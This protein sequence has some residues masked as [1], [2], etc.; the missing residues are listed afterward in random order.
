[1]VVI[2]SKIRPGRAGFV[3]GAGI[4][5]IGIVAGIALMVTGVVS[6]INQLPGFTA[7]IDAGSPQS[8]EIDQA[9]TWALYSGGQDAT[10]SGGTCAIESSSGSTVTT[11][12]PSASV[13]FTRDSRQWYWLA[14]FTVDAPGTY[15]FDCTG[16][17]SVDRFAVG[18]KPDI[19]GFAGRLVGGILGLLALPCG[20]FTI[21]LII[22]IVTAVRRSSARRKLQPVRYPTGYP[23][24]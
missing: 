3:V 7:E 10:S 15:Q 20:G 6:A 22:I 18:A 13:N 16:S 4:I 21:G 17:A 24:A 5:V 11:G 14:T 8:V 23:Q 12:K 1:M 19:T 9:G 2:E